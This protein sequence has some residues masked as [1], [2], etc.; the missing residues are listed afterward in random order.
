MLSI[1]E[2]PPNGVPINRET[3]G[4]VSRLP[5]PTMSPEASFFSATGPSKLPKNRRVVLVHIHINFEEIEFIEQLLAELDECDN[6]KSPMTFCL[7]EIDGYEQVTI[8][9]RISV[10]VH[11]PYGLLII[12][13]AYEN[14]AVAVP[15]K[16]CLQL[17]IEFH[18]GEPVTT[19]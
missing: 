5:V 7:V 10:R 3:Q 16:I 8:L 15:G 14:L 18:F 17:P 6:A 13:G 4:V 1:H 9:W 11:G 12:V 2:S 19:L